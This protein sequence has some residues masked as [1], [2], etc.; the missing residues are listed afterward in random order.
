MTFRDIGGLP[1]S[2]AVDVTSGVRGLQPLA[3]AVLRAVRRAEMIRNAIGQ[4]R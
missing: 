4:R 2:R 1:Q 3:R